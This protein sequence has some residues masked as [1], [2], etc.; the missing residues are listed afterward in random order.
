VTTSGTAVT[1]VSGNYFMGPSNSANAYIGQTMTIN[2]TAYLVSTVNSPT[3]ITLTAT[4]GTQATPV[5]YTLT[6]NC[7]LS[8]LESV[9][10][11]CAIG[12][13]AAFPTANTTTTLLKPAPTVPL[14]NVNNQ[15]PQGHT[16]FAYQPSQAPPVPFQ[17]HFGPFPVA[18]S[19]ITA[20]NNI[21]LG[22]FQLPAGYLNYIGRT[23]RVS[24]KITATVTTADTFRVII[25][26]TWPG[27]VVAGLPTPVCTAAETAT[28]SATAV[29][30]AFICTMNTNAIGNTAI[31]SIQTDI[32][33]I[34]GIA[35]AGIAGI[36]LTDSNTAAVGSLGLMAQD[37][38]FIKFGS[39]AQAASSSQLM[40]LHIE[41]LQ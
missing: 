30:I 12:A 19:G 33:A 23:V 38:F 3:S 11:A 32:R 4:A 9:Y 20:G 5:G 26:T 41:T 1:W 36:W 29:N 21:V 24:G 40:D 25:G 2:G 10:P 14:E 34:A 13:A 6:A 17:T 31:G 22:T 27:G 35:S 37:T 18:S 15:V 39:V 28:L 8:T 16:T 7:T